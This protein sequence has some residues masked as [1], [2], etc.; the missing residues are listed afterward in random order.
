MTIESVLIEQINEWLQ[1]TPYMA[2]N[3]TPSI[4]S[5]IKRRD[6]DECVILYMPLP[7]TDPRIVLNLNLWLPQ[8]IMISDS[9]EH[10]DLTNPN[11]IETIKQ[12]IMDRINEH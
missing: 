7:I 9:I 12:I 3:A 8:I 2:I 6:F 5:I 4:I 1:N 11:S 10:I